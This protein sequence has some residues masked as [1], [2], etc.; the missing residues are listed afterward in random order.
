MIGPAW[1][2]SAAKA[3]AGKLQAFGLN[4]RTFPFSRLREKVP[5][6]ADEGVGSAHQAPKK[7]KMTKLRHFPSYAA[8]K[9]LK[10]HPHPAF[11]HLLPQA[12]EGKFRMMPV[13]PGLYQGISLP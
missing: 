10:E 11:G 3:T 7:N 5:D 1:Q 8:V 13:A 4:F 9:R 2:E 6:R 12:G